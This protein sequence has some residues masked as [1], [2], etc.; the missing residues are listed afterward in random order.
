LWL[1]F[2]AMKNGSPVFYRLA[3][4][5][6][7]VAP[8]TQ[9][10]QTHLD[11]DFASQITGVE[12][13][14]ILFSILQAPRQSVELVQYLGPEGRQH[15]RPPTQRREWML[16]GAVAAIIYACQRSWAWAIVGP[17]LAIAVPVAI[18]RGVQRFQVDHRD[19]AGA[20]L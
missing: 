14:D 2:A 4:W 1:L 6:P 7:V 11:G 15:L 3:A 20:A 9:A 19:Q 16:A 10:H 18:R 13:A 5:R 8:P 12:G 17:A